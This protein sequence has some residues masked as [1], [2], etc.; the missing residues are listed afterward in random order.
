MP[1]GPG[2][3]FNPPAMFM[4]SERDAF[5]GKLI[6]PDSSTFQIRKLPKN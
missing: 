6:I 1:I 3:T 5:I 2:S 4:V